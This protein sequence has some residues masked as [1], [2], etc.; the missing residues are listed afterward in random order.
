MMTGICRMGS[1]SIF[2]NLI[3]CGSKQATTKSL[4]TPS[5]SKR[6]EK[7]APGLGEPF[8]QNGLCWPNFFIKFF[9]IVKLVELLFDVDVTNL[10]ELV[11]IILTRLHHNSA[12]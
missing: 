2:A 5:W 12:L 1:T 7:L 9:N 8:S 6:L 11:S 10:A 3:P 4:V